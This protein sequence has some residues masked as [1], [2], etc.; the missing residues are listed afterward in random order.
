M[1]ASFERFVDGDE[2]LWEN[3]ETKISRPMNKT[4]SRAKHSSIQRPIVVG[5]SSL[6]LMLLVSVA[7]TSPIQAEQ[8]SDGTEGVGQQKALLGRL[9][10]ELQISPRSFVYLRSKGFTQTDQEFEQIIAKNDTMFRRTRIVR[11]GEDGVR[12]IPGWPG[13]AVTAAY[14]ASK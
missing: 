10:T 6:M 12:Q 4:F 3:A 14:K 8:K 11:R 5:L 9:V 7:S 2:H 1:V 13:I